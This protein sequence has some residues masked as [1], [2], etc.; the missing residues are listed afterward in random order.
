MLFDG[1][2]KIVPV[3]VVWPLTEVAE[4]SCGAG[5]SEGLPCSRI[6]PRALL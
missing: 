2:P 3:I 6:P 5:W 1:E 4:V